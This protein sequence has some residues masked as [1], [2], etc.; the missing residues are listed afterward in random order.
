MN[1]EDLREQTMPYECPY[2]FEEMCDEDIIDETEYNVNRIGH[3]IGGT[4]SVFECPKC[5]EKSFIHKE[6]LGYKIWE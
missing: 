6:S 5:F 4:A 1:L 2:C 3:N